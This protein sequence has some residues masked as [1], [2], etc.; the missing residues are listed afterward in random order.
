MTE[1]T[2]HVI[3]G[4]PRSGSTLLCNILNQNPRFH[5]T[6]TSGILEII[7]AIRNQWENVSSLRA[8]PNKDGKNAVIKGILQNY[9]STVDR[10]VVFDKSRGW[11]AY[12][13]L[14]E[15]ILQRKVKLLVPVRRVVD[16]LASFE[17]LYRTQAHE[18][19]FPQEKSH[20][21]EWQ[22]A[23]GRADIWMRSDQPVGIAYNRLRDSIG[24]GFGDRMLIIEF[25]HLTSHPNETLQTIY[26]F[27][28]EEQFEHNF[29]NVEQVT[30]EDDDVHGIPG[31]HIIRPEVK[32]VQVDAK[33]FIGENAFNKYN[34]AEFWR[35]PTVGNT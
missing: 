24:R 22:T 35:N 28:E 29:T 25:E 10:P 20:F 31:L 18:W 34:N 14:A 5:A 4:L 6:S 11:A 1:K 16:I 2:I 15:H 12:I 3:A 8:S 33:R 13:E 9:Y 21:A 17:K 26:N 30:T 23:E 27:L 19:Q 32:P 7:L